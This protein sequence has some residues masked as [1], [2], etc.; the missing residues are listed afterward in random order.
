MGVTIREAN[1]EDLPELKGLKDGGCQSIRCSACDAPLLQVWITRPQEEVVWTIQAI[2]GHCGD[3]SFNKEIKGGFHLGPGVEPHKDFPDDR[4]KD[5]VYT[6][7]DKQVPENG[8]VFVE[9]IKVRE[10][11]G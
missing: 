3:H 9:T 8:V 10:Y 6:V 4:N 11:N 7:I 5:V 2:C 1:E